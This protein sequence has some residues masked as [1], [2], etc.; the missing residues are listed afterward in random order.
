MAVY[1]SEAA[2][3]FGGN[4][5]QF[6]VTKLKQVK[7][8][9]ETLIQF[10]SDVKEDKPSVYGDAFAKSPCYLESKNNS[11]IVYEKIDGEWIPR[12]LRISDRA[13]VFEIK[14]VSLTYLATIKNAAVISRRLWNSKFRAGNPDK[15]DND[16]TA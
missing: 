10:A 4:K 3:M 14:N 13:T 12:N 8:D 15:T 11:I 9:E 2:E 6:L 1:E 16:V 5:S 7:Y